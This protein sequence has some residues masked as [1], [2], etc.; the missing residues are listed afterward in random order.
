MAEWNCRIHRIQ[1]RSDAERDDQIK[2]VLQDY[3]AEGWE[4]VQVF[5]RLKESEDPVYRLIFKAEK[6]LD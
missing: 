6:T 4:L 1:V 2:T 3:D 5:H